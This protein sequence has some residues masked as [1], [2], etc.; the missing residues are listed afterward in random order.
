MVSTSQIFIPFYTNG[1]DL[2]IEISLKARW[3]REGS[4]DTHPQPEE[5]GELKGILE[6]NTRKISLG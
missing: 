5:V 6:H 1:V 3:L 4:V 2:F